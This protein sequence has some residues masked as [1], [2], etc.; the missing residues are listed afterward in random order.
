MKFYLF[1]MAII[2]ISL[3]FIKNISAFPQIEFV[4]PTPPDNNISINNWSYVNVSTSDTNNHSAF[5]DW[6]RSLVGWWSMDWYNSTGIYDNST[7]DNFGTFYGGLST[8]NITTGKRGN[9]LEFDGID[10]YVLLGDSALF[11]Q[12][13]TISL[14]TKYNQ[15][16]DY[17]M[18]MGRE[19][20]N[21]NGFR[22]GFGGAENFVFWTSQS[23]G[24][25][26]LASP[27][28]SSNTWY[29]VVVTYNGSQGIM[30]LDGVAGTPS[31]GTYVYNPNVLVLAGGVGG[32]TR[33]NGTIDEVMI[34]NRALTPE[35]VNASYQAGTYRLY[36]NFANLSDGVYDYTA[37]TINSEGDSN[38]TETRTFIIDYS[39]PTQDIPIILTNY[40]TNYTIDDIY[41]LN[42]STADEDNDTVVNK[43]I[44]FNNGV[45]IPG[46]ENQTIL[47]FNQ[48]SGG[49][50]I[51]CQVTPFDGKVDGTSYN[52]TGLIIKDAIFLDLNTS[53][54]NAYSSGFRSYT[55]PNGTYFISEKVSV[56]EGFTISGNNTILTINV[57]DR[58]FNLI[59]SVGTN[60][61]N[62]IQDLILEGRGVATLGIDAYGRSNIIISNLEIR[63]TKN[64][65]IRII[66]DYNYNS[67]SIN[68]GVLD[69]CPTFDIN[70]DFTSIDDVYSAFQECPS[71]TN[72]I[73]QL[74]KNVTIENCTIN[75]AWVSGTTYDGMIEAERVHG[76]NITG[77]ELTGTNTYG[78]K[79]FN[80]G[81]FS[82]FYN[83]VIN[84]TRDSVKYPSSSPCISIETWNG[85]WFSK[86]YNNNVNR[87]LSIANSH[88]AKVW[89]N[90]V[91]YMSNYISPKSY[92]IEG[93]ASDSLY[94]FN[95]LVIGATIG[96]SIDQGNE[97][98]IY[99]SNKILDST[100]YGMQLYG[101]VV[102]IH[103]VT[104]RNNFVYNTT[105]VSGGIY[106]GR[107]ILLNNKIFSTNIENNIIADSYDSG[108]YLFV[109]TDTTVVNNTIECWAIGGTGAAIAR[110]TDTGTVFMDNT[111]RPCVVSCSGDPECDDDNPCT[112]DSCVDSACQN[113]A[114][115]VNTCS[116]N[117]YCTTN[118][119]CLRG[120]CVTDAIDCDDDVTLT[121]D[122]CN[123]TTKSCSHDTRDFTGCYYDGICNTGLGESCSTCPF[124]CGTCPSVPRGG[125]GGCSYNWDCTSW[126]P[127]E[128]PV[129]E[130]QERI[131]ANRGTCIGIIGMPNQTQYCEYQHKE[132]LFDIFLEISKGFQE[133]CAGNKIKANVKL[134]NYGRIEP[135]DA[136]MTY[137]IIDE[138]NKLISE[139]KDTRNVADKIDF[140]IMLKI[141]ESTSEGTYRLYVQMTYSEN[142]T[143]VAGE[144]FEVIEE[145]F[146]EISLYISEYINFIIGFLIFIMLI[147][148]IILFRKFLH[149]IKKK[150]LKTREDIPK[151]P[152][153]KKISRNQTKKINLKKREKGKKEAE[154]KRRKEIIEEV[155]NL[156]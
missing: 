21:V 31:E 120:Y 41:C 51:T 11:N 65:A 87:W 30:Y 136:F 39:I 20:W 63:N 83:N 61:N 2:L 40:S 139:V 146:C 27:P 82:Y 16:D 102:P 86:F 90:T 85:G 156:K 141:P 10:D 125:S 140:D 108:L 155:R 56:P 72:Y 113:T 17:E 14:W 44:W 97:R 147:L 105:N 62:V 84:I 148:I 106:S 121:V 71:F 45:V 60:G 75:N 38:K 122:I 107:G 64:E 92:G 149:P 154:E 13:F 94:V 153:P 138:N 144:S 15:F 59:S 93:V 22:Y 7:Y 77:C 57:S 151:K 55:L 115:D 131:C 46:Y 49:D 73:N 50:N 3:F 1:L 110:N 127:L 103:N 5:I 128:C 133:I 74:A 99:E 132:P 81:S 28:T 142:K 66:G 53:I 58:F 43:I 89:N 69:I 18:L 54:A 6:N 8:D 100:I 80:W 29:H 52:S 104:L 23:G 48:T 124:E 152:I 25:L 98:S 101:S 111:Q 150:K 129:S 37:Y 68:E 24:T 88:G 130:I 76:I 32:T 91:N 4:S 112:D 126:F 145:D 9:A 109:T 19:V 118:E 143:A 135:L 137:W 123:E 116:D 47:P 114:N 70:M 33:W 36:H 79:V 42:Q 117:L 34:F 119:R 96:L 134:E 67:I 35:E 78:I 26:G 95:N 12:T